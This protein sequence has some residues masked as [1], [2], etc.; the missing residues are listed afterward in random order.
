MTLEKKSV[1]K[2]GY[3][4]WFA[5][6]PRKNCLPSK[7]SSTSTL[8]ISSSAAGTTSV[9]RCMQACKTRHGHQTPQAWH[10][11]QM[12]TPPKGKE[13]K[14]GCT[15]RGL[16]RTGALSHPG[17]MKLLQRPSEGHEAAGTGISEE[18][19]PPWWRGTGP[20]QQGNGGSRRPPG[21]SSCVAAP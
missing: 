13:G 1:W 8:R 17:V 10:H 21:S 5:M 2:L 7:S 18:G 16:S 19:N 12:M 11:I 4:N 14:Q 3:R 15:S 6:T 20:G 9:V